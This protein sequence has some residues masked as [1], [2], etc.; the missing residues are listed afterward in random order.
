MENKVSIILCTYNEANF[1]EKAINLI[2]QNLQQAELIIVDDSSTDGTIEKLNKLKTNLNFKLIVRKRT[3]GLASA[4]NRGMMSASGDYIGFVDANCPDQVL[5][6]KK[7]MEILDNGY[8]VAILSRYV[9]GG[10]DKRAFIRSSSSWLINFVCRI[11]LRVSIKDFSGGLFLLRRKILDDVNIIPYGHGEFF[12]EFIYDVIKKGF[13]V[14][15]LP[16]IQ[17]TDS[18]TNSKSNPNLLHFC[19]LGFLYFLRIFITIFR[20]N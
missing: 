15:E 16:Y 2:F 3:K 7:M 19:Y 18:M 9:D 14:K 8:D 12:I 13:K 20:R 17:N 6:F 10:G 5:Y 4:V 1:I 11:I